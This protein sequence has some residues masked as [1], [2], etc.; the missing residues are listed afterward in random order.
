M[1][2]LRLEPLVA[3]M[4]GAS[5]KSVG[6]RGLLEMSGGSCSKASRNLTK[7]GA[8]EQQPEATQG[9]QIRQQFLLGH[10][11]G[12]QVRFTPVNDGAWVTL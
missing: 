12:D 7:H 10:L 3:G 4:L 8:R 1:S 5:P 2:F 11:H 9:G 6:G